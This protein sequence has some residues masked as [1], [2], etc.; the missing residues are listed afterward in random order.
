LHTDKETQCKTEYG[1]Q[2]PK[3]DCEKTTPT[4]TLPE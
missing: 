3:D 1:V 2:I 4:G